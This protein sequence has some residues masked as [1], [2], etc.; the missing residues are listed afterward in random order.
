MF[1]QFMIWLPSFN[2]YFFQ[3]KSK[4]VNIT[5]VLHEKYDVDA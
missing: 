4:C 1:V 5:N 3:R 2:I